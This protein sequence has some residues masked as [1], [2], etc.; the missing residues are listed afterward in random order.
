[1]WF[2]LQSWSKVKIVLYSQMRSDLLSCPSGLPF[3]LCICC[4]LECS[5]LIFLVQVVLSSLCIFFLLLS[6]FMCHL[7]YAVSIW[8]SSF[9][10]DNWK[11]L[12]LSFY[13]VSFHFLP[14]SKIWQ[15]INF[16]SCF[17]NCWLDNALISSQ[18]FYP[19]LPEK[20]SFGSPC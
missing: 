12:L 3:I 10:C 14:S 11:L 8:S 7:N 1:M 6:G 9:S 16:G 2:D 4:I 17:Y 13:L 5:C 15:S 18:T 20:L 19:I